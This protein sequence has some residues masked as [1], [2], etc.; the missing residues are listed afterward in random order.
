M[1]TKVGGSIVERKG[2]GVKGK[3]FLRS[4]RERSKGVEGLEKIR[5]VTGERFKELLG[6][7]GYDEGKRMK[8]MIESGKI[9]K[10]VKKEI[11]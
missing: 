3:K 11:E 8:A 10:G 2:K 7:R 6:G 5:G 4:K 9:R 1:V